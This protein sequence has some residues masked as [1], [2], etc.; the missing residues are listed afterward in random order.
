MLQALRRDQLLA[1]LE[2]VDDEFT[3]RQRHEAIVSDDT[4]IDFASGD[5]LLDDGVRPDVVVN[6]LNALCEGLVTANDRG[7][8]DSHRGFLDE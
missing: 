7:L 2:F 3:R 8:G 4:D 1:R 5:E 6:E